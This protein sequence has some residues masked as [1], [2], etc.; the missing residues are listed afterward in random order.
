MQLPGVASKATSIANASS[1]LRA[2]AKLASRD[3]ADARER[4]ENWCE[5]IPVGLQEFNAPAFASQAWRDAC[6]TSVELTTMCVVQRACNCVLAK[7]FN[8]ALSYFCRFIDPN[9]SF[10]QSDSHL[11]KC[12][13]KIRVGNVDDEVCK[14]FG[15][16]LSRQLQPSNGLVP[17]RLTC[18][19]EQAVS[20]V[21]RLCAILLVGMT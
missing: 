6:F 13:G 10:R 21:A 11:I 16:T 17:T 3:D 19:N 5:R 12:L 9:R 7:M 18:K 8:A 1:E 14:H 15:Q 2:A 4:V 20:C